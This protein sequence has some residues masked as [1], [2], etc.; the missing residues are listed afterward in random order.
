MKF[1]LSEDNEILMYDGEFSDF[2]CDVDITPKEK[3]LIDCYFPVNKFY[4]IDGTIRVGEVRDLSLTAEETI[5]QK[6]KERY[7]LLQ[8]FDRWE[9]AVL[10]GREQDSE[11]IMAWFYDLLDLKD[12]AF[13]NIPERVQYYIL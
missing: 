2:T 1:K 11:E 8:A 7:T 13:V 12:E 6:R 9:K 10:R 3:K 5:R 4:L